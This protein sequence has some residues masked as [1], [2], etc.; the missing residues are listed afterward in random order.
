VKLTATDTC[1]FFYGT[2]V[3]FRIYV[4]SGLL[5]CIARG[6]FPKDLRIV[7]HETRILMAESAKRTTQCLLVAWHF[8][9]L[10]YNSAIKLVPPLAVSSS[11]L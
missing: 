1:S 10:T 8:H 11:F 4:H 5:R 9:V 2:L 3:S 6:L 7:E